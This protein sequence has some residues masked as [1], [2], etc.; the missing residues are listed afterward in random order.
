M[1][2]SGAKAIKSLAAANRRP[3]PV[4]GTNK[5]KRVS[6][7]KAANGIV[8][9]THMD[10]SGGPYKEP[11]TNIHASMSHAVKHLKEKFGDKE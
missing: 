4:G 7:E 1:S 3:N 5:V 9:T 2:I 8:S 11:E 6:F 10:D